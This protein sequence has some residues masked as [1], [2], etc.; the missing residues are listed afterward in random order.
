MNNFKLCDVLKLKRA[1]KIL[2]SLSGLTYV[3]HY[4]IL[5]CNFTSNFVIRKV[6]GKILPCLY[7]TA[8]SARSPLVREPIALPVLVSL[9]TTK[10]N[11]NIYNYFLNTM[12]D[13]DRIVFPEEEKTLEVDVANVEDKTTG[14][15]TNTIE[16]ASPNVEMRNVVVVPPNCPKGYE[17][18][19]DGVCREVF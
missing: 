6:G 14:G 5:K 10:S 12:A 2:L 4:I 9:N 15:D 11:N 16:E 18:S 7:I 17:M 3:T 8:Q 13:S 1:I 19:A